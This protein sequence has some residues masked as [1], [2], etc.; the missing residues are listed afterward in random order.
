LLSFRIASLG[1]NL[2]H[3]SGRPV[4]LRDYSTDWNVW[5]GAFS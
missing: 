5:M 2:C 3:T 4:S 1:V